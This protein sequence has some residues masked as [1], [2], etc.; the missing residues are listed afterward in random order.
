MLL[1]LAAVDLAPLQPTS[2]GK[3]RAAA[4][5]I[6]LA[7][8]FR[9]LRAFQPTMSSARARRA[10]EQADRAAHEDAVS[11]YANLHRDQLRAAALSLLQDR[12]RG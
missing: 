10:A 8:C 4:R 2:P 11:S 1:A 3:A 7:E 5:M 9:Y 6:A 12:E